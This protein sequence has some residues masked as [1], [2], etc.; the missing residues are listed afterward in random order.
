MNAQNLSELIVRWQEARRQG[1]DLTP[2]E[3]GAESP[4]ML[5][6]LGRQI[7]ALEAM[8]GFLSGRS[9]DT[10]C[11]AETA[12]TFV[13]PSVP[14]YEVRRVLGRGGMGVVYEACQQSLGRTVALKMVLAG[15]DAGFAELVRFRTEAEALARLQHP[16]VVQIFD[17]GEHAGRPFL[18]LEYLEGGSLAD[19]LAEAALEPRAAA[20]LVEALAHGV[21]AI[22]DKG[23]IHR[24]L[25]PGNVLLAADGTPKVADFGLAKR[26]DVDQGLSRM[27]DALGTPSYMAPEQA[28]GRTSEVGPA[29]DVYSLGAIL[30]ECLAR[31]PPFR[32]RTRAETVLQ[33]LHDDALPPRGL[34]AKTP[35]DLE[36]IC[37]KCLEKDPRRR[38]AT[39]AALTEDLRRFL[40]GQPTLARPLGPGR[41]ALKWAR[42]RPTAAA[43]LGV[44][45]LA[46]LGALVGTGWHSVQLERYYTRLEGLNEDLRETAQREQSERSRAETQNTLFRRQLRFTQ[47]RAAVHEWENGHLPQM[48]EWLQDCPPEDRCLA[49]LELWRQGRRQVRLLRTDELHCNQVAFTPDGRTLAVSGHFGRL[50]LWDP[51]T[52]QRRA[53]LKGHQGDVKLVI[54]PDG[55]TLVSGGYDDGKAIL[56]DVVS[57]R[58]LGRLPLQPGGGVT[59]LS[60]SPDSRKLVVGMRHQPT[61]VWDC[62][63]REKLLELP[64]RPGWT[65]CVAFSPDGTTLAVGYEEQLVWLY[66]ATTGH[67][68]RQLAVKDRYANVLAWSPDGQYL[69]VGGR[70]GTAHLWD[71]TP[72]AKPKPIPVDSRADGI[73]VGL[74]FSP[75]GRTLVSAGGSHVINLWDVV[76]GRSRKQLL[77]TRGLESVAFRPDGSGLA[78]TNRHDVVLFTLKPGRQPHSLGMHYD[79]VMGVAFA[80]DGRLLATASE[81]ASVVLWDPVTGQ[82]HDI[83]RHDSPVYAVAFAPDGRTLAA[84]CRTG[85]VCLWDLA[86]GTVR[87]TLRGHTDRVWRV[88]FSS[89]GRTLASAG[90]EGTVR[91]WDAATGAERAVLH[92]HPDQV[93]SLVFTPDGRTLISGSKAAGTQ[94]DKVLY[95]W[96]PRT[97]EKLRTI[98]SIMEGWALAVSPDGRMLAQGDSGGTVVLWDLK[99]DQRLAALP[100]PPGYVHGAAFTPDGQTLVTSHGKYLVFW[101]VATRQELLRQS[102]HAKKV[103]DLA[104]AP[105]GRTLATVGLDGAVRLWG[106]VG[107]QGSTFRRGD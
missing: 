59:G 48:V 101:D 83:L 37:L 13:L 107:E 1:R 36:S 38:Y 8:W 71:M 106:E 66:D 16:H 43:L 11:A 23:V 102:A 45:I 95:L 25:K 82:K 97:G 94:Y 86:T 69:A 57:G 18:A 46:V 14:G 61:Y 24:D 85:E 80:P 15:V 81:D 72:G 67:V 88:A 49:W 32:G 78:F 52:E 53:V 5:A 103:H 12:A 42:R 35:H 51:E 30:Y 22:H 90:R 40:H 26:L 92:G 17:V 34:N 55:R 10:G 56:W 7:Q 99:S 84:G 65:K 77:P 89:D 105:N 70:D 93:R 47:M 2:Q 96:D 73:V 28:A 75:D 54:A 104:L 100:G 91:L 74:A 63:T 19:R 4:E 62:T 44:S 98:P 64:V 60:F 58:E 79:Q 27:G 6:E 31:R 20:R 76:M 87:M 3:L 9:S 41:R 33:V 21:Q 68:Q 39:A 29:A 50:E